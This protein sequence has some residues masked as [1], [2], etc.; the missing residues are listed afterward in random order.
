[1]ITRKN[2][3]KGV[4]AS[5]SLFSI[6][7]I[8]KSQETKLVFHSRFANLDYWKSRW[9]AF[10]PLQTC[11]TCRDG[12]DCP[13]RL[14]KCKIIVQLKSGEVLEDEGIINLIALH[15]FDGGLLMIKITTESSQKEKDPSRY[16]GE[17]CT[18]VRIEQDMFL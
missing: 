3:L 12:A 6:P 7:A 8:A 10:H 1:M 16:A 11:V 13:L 9:F 18:Y 4:L 15:P 17:E 14:G 2:F 5:V